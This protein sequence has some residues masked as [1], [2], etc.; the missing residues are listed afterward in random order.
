MKSCTGATKGIT[1]QGL[2]KRTMNKFE[3]LVIENAEY[4]KKV[5]ISIE[6]APEK[7]EDERISKDYK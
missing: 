5:G 1:L 7:G 4:A 2:S 3:W 6:N